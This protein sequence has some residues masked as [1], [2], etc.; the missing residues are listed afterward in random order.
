MVRFQQATDSSLACWVVEDASIN[1][2]E[3]AQAVDRRGAMVVTYDDLGVVDQ[4]FFHPPTPVVI[5]LPVGIWR[6]GQSSDGKVYTPVMDLQSNI[7]SRGPGLRTNI[8]LD[9][10][11]NMA[12]GW[13]R[14]TKL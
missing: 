14:Y 4:E 7:T 6:W 2:V 11:M 8:I 5:I 9:P 10:P 1:F 3:V 13:S 12:P